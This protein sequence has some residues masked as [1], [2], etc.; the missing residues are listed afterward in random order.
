M[1]WKHLNC[2]SLQG[3]CRLKGPH[4]EG[5]GP[6]CSSWTP[7]ESRGGAHCPH[8]YPPT[9]AHNGGI[10]AQHTPRG[11]LLPQ[12]AM[13]PICKPLLDN[14]MRITTGGI[15]RSPLRCKSAFLEFKALLSFGTPPIKGTDRKPKSCVLKTTKDTTNQQ[16]N[17]TCRGTGAEMSLSVI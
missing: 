9:V 4:S 1:I 14:G 2:D 12:T 16:S 17:F 3:L 8:V 5:M 15:P 6:H 13:C 10:S 11:Y 7:P